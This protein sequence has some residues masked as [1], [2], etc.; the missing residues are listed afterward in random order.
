MSDC[1]TFAESP[2]D[3]EEDRT[4][5][6]ALIGML[7][8][9]EC[10]YPIQLRRE[11]PAE[12]AGARTSPRGIRPHDHLIVS[13]SH[14]VSVCLVGRSIVQDDEIE[15]GQ[16]FGVGEDVKLDDPSPT[17]LTSSR[18]RLPPPCRLRAKSS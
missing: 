16:P 15:L 7:R 12:R 11:R 2:I 10:Q 18:V 9:A 17:G 1:R 3:C 13:P 6:A 4:L 8:E 14:R 5:R